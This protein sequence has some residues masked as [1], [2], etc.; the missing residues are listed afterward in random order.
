MAVYRLIKDNKVVNTIIADEVESIR[1]QYDLIEEVV[2]TPQPPTPVIITI[3]ASTVRNNLTFA[4]RVKWDNNLTPSI[5]TGKLEFS[6]PRTVEDAREI[7]NFLV[8]EGDISQSSADKVIAS[9][10]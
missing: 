9:V 5:T 1:D 7:L 6:S 4:E 2:D 8:S 3:E 10:G